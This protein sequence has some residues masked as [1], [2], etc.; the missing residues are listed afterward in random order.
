MVEKLVDARTKT[1]ET[2]NLLKNYARTEK[3]QKCEHRM[4]TCL[5]C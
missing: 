5:N 3:Y 2:E 4:S 1:T